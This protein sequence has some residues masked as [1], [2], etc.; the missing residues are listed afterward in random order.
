MRLIK[1][2]CN[3]KNK[4]DYSFDTTGKIFYINAGA[5]KYVSKRQYEFYVATTYM[6]TEYYQKVRINIANVYQVPIALI[7]Y[8]HS[9]ITNA[10]ILLCA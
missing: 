1:M 5:L 2:Y 7:R 3:T 10:F 9:Y 8:L 6:N 4:D